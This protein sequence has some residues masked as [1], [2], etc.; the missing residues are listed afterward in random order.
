MSFFTDQRGEPKPVRIF[1]VALL[2]FFLV[3]GI[4][5][6]GC[7]IYNVWE[8][9]LAGEAELRQAEW[10]RQIK[11]K[12]AEAAQQSAQ[13]LAAAEIERAKGVAEANRI[14]G[15]SLRNN[16][17]YLRYLWIHN[18]ES[19]EAKGATIIY[20]PTEA[21]LPILEASRKPVR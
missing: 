2:G 12:E 1:G 21:N 5:M 10:N 7:P 3:L 16:E 6:A 11:I 4:A 15:E 20:V 19:A 17:D 18:L 9:G 13:H 14:I 8:R